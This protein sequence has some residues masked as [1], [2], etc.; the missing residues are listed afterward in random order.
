[1]IAPVTYNDQVIRF[2]I[3]NPEDHLQKFWLKGVFYEQTMLN[4]IEKFK[5][6]KAQPIIIDIGACIGNHTVFF[7]KV[8]NAFVYA[9]EPV[10]ENV[11]LLKENCELNNARPNVWIIP[12]GAGQARTKVN[13]QKDRSGNSGMGKISPSGSDIIQLMP[14]D[15]VIS[16]SHEVDVLK[17]DVE[18]YNIPVLE[19]AR[20]TIEQDHPEIYIEC[21]TPAELKEVEDLLLPIG[22]TRYPHPFNATPTYLFYY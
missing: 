8:M 9:F 15:S 5:K 16:H 22:Y 14:V 13:F 17:I 12:H 10:K 21:Q 4:C 11:E 1:M 2:R 20:Q 18:G 7:A 6:Y 3:T 19:G